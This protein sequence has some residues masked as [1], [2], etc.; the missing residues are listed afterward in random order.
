MYRYD[1]LSEAIKHALKVDEENLLEGLENLSRK[2]KRYITPLYDKC[3][4]DIKEPSD[5]LTLAKLHLPL[6]KTHPRKQDKINSE[7]ILDVPDLQRTFNA[8]RQAGLGLP[9]E[10][11][12]SLTLTMR[13][14][15]SQN[16]TKGLRFWG[17]ICGTK[18]NYYVLEVD[19]DMSNETKQNAG[20]MS[21]DQRVSPLPADVHEEELDALDL[22]PPPRPDWKPPP[23]LMAEEPGKGLNK[24]AYYVCNQ[25][26]ERWEKLPDVTP[27]QIS[28]SRMIRCFFTGELD[29]EMKSY[30]P[31]PGLEKNYLRA[32]IARISATT[33]I[34][35]NNYYQFD[36][37]EEESAEEDAF[38][39]SFIQNP[40]Y[41]PMSIFDLTDSSL[42]NWVHHTAYILPQG[43]T[44]WLNPKSKSQSEN[45]GDASDDEEEDEG[46]LEEPDE[47][48]PE[49]GPPLLTP[50]SEDAQVEGITPWTTRITSRLVPH[51]AYAVLSSNLWHGAHAIASGRFFENIYIG[52]GQKFIGSNF[53]PQFTPPVFV[54]FPSGPEVTEVEDPT[55]EEEAAWKAAQAEAAERAA[56]QHQDELE[57]EEDDEGDSE[58][59]DDD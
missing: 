19:Q 58:A 51:Y 27:L 24:K 50:L 23:N 36:E 35:P 44:I 20:L 28:V 39:E 47:P 40:E 1:H 48:E 37:D 31:F 41:E 21:N 32:Q 29:A 33:T 45:E 8:F 46:E 43:R 17:K 7:P 16:H 30:P 54:E 3:L 57:E 26:G 5:E 42:A 6:F 53:S 25:I 13:K 55:P 12:L 38:R 18:K 49:T 59:I 4:K 56:G 52:W 11:V 2:L 22:D 10:E 34:S 14:F 15:I 9:N